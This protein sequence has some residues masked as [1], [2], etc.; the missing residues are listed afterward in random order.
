MLPKSFV[1]FL[2]HVA[3][4]ATPEMDEM[5]SNLLKGRL[6]KTLVG[7]A[8]FITLNERDLLCV[9]SRLVLFIPKSL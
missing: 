1:L 7:K 4:V 6:I 2:T 3:V 5:P 9:L 8:A